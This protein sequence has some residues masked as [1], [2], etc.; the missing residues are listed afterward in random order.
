MSWP[1]VAFMVVFAAEAIRRRVP[2]IPAARHRVLVSLGL[3]T[4]VTLALLFGLRI[5]L[6]NARTVVPLAGIVVGD[7]LTATVVG[8]PGRA[9]R[10]AGATGDGPAEAAGG[11]GH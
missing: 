10:R 7:S 2:E 6:V 5:F 9:A 4:V 3:A 1:W 11:H 8:R